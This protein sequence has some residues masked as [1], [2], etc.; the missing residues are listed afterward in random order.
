[1]SKDL[2]NSKIFPELLSGLESI[3]SDPEF[4]ESFARCHDQICVALLCLQMRWGSNT[5]LSSEE[6]G[7]RVSVMSDIFELFNGLRPE[8]LVDSKK[9]KTPPKLPNRRI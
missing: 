9:K 2:T 6:K 4:V 8:S 5:N 3:K 7:L 1:M